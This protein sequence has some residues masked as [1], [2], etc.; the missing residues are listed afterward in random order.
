MANF[1]TSKQITK[2]IEGGFW[3]DPSAGW[4]YAGIT[5]KY[6]PWWPGFNRLKILQKIHFGSKPIK[7]YT[8]FEDAQLNQLVDIFYKNNFWNRLNGD[9]II[10]QQLANLMWDF[11]VHKEYDAIAI[12][13]RAAAFIDSDVQVDESKVTTAV[14][15]VINTAPRQ[16]YSMLRQG[17][18]NYY[19]TKRNKAGRLLFSNALQQSLIERVNKFPTSI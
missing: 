3:D 11:F 9:V 6:Y 10:N 8:I 15:R 16:F 5:K 4:T 13:N 7:R 1:F 2:D 14:V 18:I 19:K 17:R 12:I